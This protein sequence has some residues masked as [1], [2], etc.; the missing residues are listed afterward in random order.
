MRAIGS[1]IS[2]K[3]EP[4]PYFKE[5]VLFNGRLRLKIRRLFLLMD[6]PSP[7]LERELVLNSLLS[8]LIL[9]HGDQPPVPYQT[10]SHYSAIKRVCEFIKTH[11]AD[12]LSLKQL[13]R[14]ACLSS[15]Y[16]QRL[17]LKN[18]GVSPHDYMIHCR[19]KKARELLAEGHS[20]A[21]VALDVGFVDQSHFTRSFKQVTGTT[22]GIYISAA[23]HNTR[24]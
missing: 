16:F 5:T 20:I 17:F 2:E 10:G 12:H 1:Q 9:R 3:A 8:S 6:N 4:I 15:F 13:S 24:Q 14:V 7:S 18:T 11:Y 22:P 19:I 21:G 23:R